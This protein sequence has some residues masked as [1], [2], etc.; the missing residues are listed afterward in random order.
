ML[1]DEADDRPA[2]QHQ[3]HV[4]GVR[5]GMPSFEPERLTEGKAR[6]TFLAVDLV[7]PNWRDGKGPK[8]PTHTR[9]P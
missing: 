2:G 5:I 6:R 1:G 9:I 3:S 8:F 4:I 7:S